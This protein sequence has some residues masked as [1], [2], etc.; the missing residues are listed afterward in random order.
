M[1]DADAIVIED[2]H[3]IGATLWTDFLIDGIAQERG[4]HRAAL[5][6]SDLDGWIRNEQG[7]GRFTTYDS[8]RRPAE[9][10][11]FIKDVLADA[12]R[13]ATTAVVITHPQP[14]SRSIAP[15]F[16][17]SALNPAF[18]SNLEPLI[19]RHQ[20]ALWTHGQSSRATA[21]PCGDVG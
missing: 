10:R 6:I 12:R 9:D 4:A 16:H 3:F 15:R 11:T 5:G 8:V 21:V 20:P 18:A 17:G 19:A 1:L 7:T 13:D 14:T 2:V